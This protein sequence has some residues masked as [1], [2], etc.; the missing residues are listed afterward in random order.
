MPTRKTATPDLLDDHLLRAIANRGGVRNYAAN[1]VLVTEDAR[2]D[3]LVVILSGRVKAYGSAEDGREVV[4]ST[5]AVGEYFGELTLDG[6]PRSA[7]VMTLE[8]TTCAV[9]PGADVRQFLAENPDF[10][11]HLIKKLIRLARSSTEH[12]KSLALDDVYGRVTKLLRTLA[13]D[14]NG[15]LTVPDKLTQ[16][17]IAERVGSSREMVSR[18][19][20]PLTEGGYVATSGGRIVL[21]KKLPA[22]F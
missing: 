4:Y 7:S 12:V 22:R 3:T 14:E 18:V 9:V 20:K 15:V 17:D 2:S 8:P 13:Q 16:Q 5:Q 19:F 11:L 21:L 6:G 10:A 1:A